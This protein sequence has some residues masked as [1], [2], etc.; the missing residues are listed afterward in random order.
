MFLLITGPA[1]SGRT[2][3]VALFGSRSCPIALSKPGIN[4]PLIA[5]TKSKDTDVLFRTMCGLCINLISLGCG[6]VCRGGP[7]WPPL[8]PI[9]AP[10][11]LTEG[12][13]TEGHPYN[14]SHY[15][16]FLGL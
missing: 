3:R 7:P 4:K 6:H 1:W 14:C 5:N 2:T 9:Q 12:V 16:L 8:V 10:R 11:K 13:A 15:R